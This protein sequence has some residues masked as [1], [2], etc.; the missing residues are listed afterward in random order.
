[1]KQF[2]IF[3]LIVLG[4]SSCFE[5]PYKVG[6]AVFV[7]TGW[8]KETVFGVVVATR[9]SQLIVVKLCDGNYITANIDQTVIAPAGTAA[10]HV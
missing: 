2:L 8:T 7:Q 9:D 10:C 6:D 4:L 5:N 3:G 1:M